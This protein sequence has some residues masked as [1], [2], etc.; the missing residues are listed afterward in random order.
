MKQ[1]NFSKQLAFLI[2]FI[3]LGSFTASAQLNG[4]YTIGG[5]SPDY[6][7]LSSAITALNV[8]GVSGPVTFN[9]RSG[10][11]T[12]TTWRGQ[13][14][15]VAGASATNRVTFKAETGNAADVTI[16]VTGS[17][18]A[19]YIFKLNNA[20]YITIRNLTLKNTSTSY[21][22][23]VEFAGQSSYDSL[24]NCVITG[25]KT[26]STSQNTAT[27]MAYSHTGTDNVVYN[28]TTND[29]SS[30]IYVRGSSTVTTSNNWRIVGNTVNMTSS[31]YYCMY[32]YYTRGNKYLNNT[33]NYTGTSTCYVAYMY[34][35]T[36]DF[37]FSDN[38]INGSSTS[39][40]Y[41][42]LYYIN[43]SPSN[44]S[45]NVKVQRNTYNLTNTGGTTYV[46]NRYMYN[47]EQSDNEYN[48]TSSTGGKSIDMLYYV[49]NS[50]SYDNVINSK[51][52]SSGYTTVYDSYY[53][54]S[55]SEF[56]DNEINVDHASGTSAYCN[57]YMLYY[58]AGGKSYDNT[59][60]VNNNTG[61]CYLYTGY[62]SANGSMYDCVFNVTSNT[63]IIYGARPQYGG[64]NIYNNE[65]NFTSNTGTI[66]GLYPYY[67]SGGNI[68]SNT[69]NLKTSGTV[70]NLYTGYCTG[71]SIFNNTIHAN[72]HNSSSYL[73][74]DYNTS[75]GNMKV[76]NNIFSRSG[77]SSNMV[78]V[79]NGA[80]TKFEYNLYSTPGT[81]KFNS[82]SPS[83]NTD[84]LH[85]WRKDAGRD[86]NSLVYDVPYTNAAAGDFSILA[87]SAAAWAVNGRGMHDTMR[88]IDF[89][90]TPCPR[91]TPDG[92]PDIGAFEVSPTSTPPNATATP[93]NPVAN[94][95]QVFTFGQDTVMTIDWGSSV[96]STYTVRQYTGLKAN[97]VPTGLQR[98]FFYTAG[99]PAT[100]LHTYKANVYYKDPW[101]GDIPAETDAVLAR[102]SNGGAWEGYNYSNAATDDLNNILSTAGTLD[103]IGSYTGVM[104]GRIGIR[105]VFAPTGIK[106]SNITAFDADIDWDPVFNPLGYQVVVKTSPTAPTPSEWANAPFPA[107]NSL[108]A[109]G[110]TEDTKYY[111]FIRN[112]CGLKDT[113][114][115]T[116]DSFT[117]IITCH[118]PT[119]TISALG[120]ERAVV[121]WDTIKTATHYEYALTTTMTP[122]SAG[123]NLY[124]TSQLASFL[125]NGKTYYAHVRAKCNTI[126]SE[127]DWTTVE[128][129]TW[130]TSVNSLGIENTVSVYPNPARNSIVVTIGG[131]TI[132]DGTLTIMDV[133]GKQLKSIK[134]SSNTTTVD[135]NE[136]PAGMY[137][138]RY[139]NDDHTEQ[140]KFTKQ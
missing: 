51:S 32:N 93:A 60:N 136:L 67:M 135:V 85:T 68:Y 65:F 91:F 76:Y 129:T 21:G 20:S 16:N 6:T 80:N 87:N 94:G 56:H 88:H 12:A 111:L 75:S 95:T 5:T 36:D 101:I 55:G 107:T 82:N 46:Y 33:V 64:A 10:S 108:S 1:F 14:N 53:P 3:T 11:Y 133:T 57:I 59:Y 35:N 123:T 86:N 31:G 122:P 69:F 109:G 100:W 139:A 61:Y 110:L 25:G 89:A 28:N 132:S 124:K 90:G 39:T 105:C 106:V 118:A 138:V 22:V 81:L 19:N 23:S 45:A 54:Q 37:E 96:P 49:Y 2:A 43:Y 104:N 102:S 47:V 121:S 115:Y 70:Y 98:M 41:A 112:V 26:T 127:S 44:T 128:F 84:N 24:M 66:Y 63:G 42:S 8:L 137:I 83:V 52:T 34:Y 7:T 4:V 9:I 131:N 126:Y 27:I 125:D 62:T 113:S 73:V 13:I 116:M 114:G 92:V 72:S 134:V 58:G 120:N 119:V 50:E 17:S 74:Y 78:Y 15:T 77:S 140:V 38:T 71:G 40:M 29:G 117:T 18:S 103:S 48:V 130:K 79:Y 99:T 97:P 30:G